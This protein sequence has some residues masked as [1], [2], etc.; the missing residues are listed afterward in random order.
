MRTKKYI[1]VLAL[2]M[3]MAA[4]VTG[5]GGG[6]AT[7]TADVVK[8]G[9]VLSQSGFLG[10][11]G[12]KMQKAV[13]MAVADINAAGG[14]NGKQVK[15]YTEDDAT[16]AAQC[17]NAVKKLVEVNGVQLMI[18][19]MTSGAANTI[20]PYL[21][22]REVL[23]LSPSA[24]AAT[25]TGQPWRDFF[26]RTTPTDAYQ[27]KVMAKLAL[28]RGLKRLVV[29]TMDNP[30]GVGLGQ[31]AEA[32]L[33]AGGAEVVGFIKYDPAKMDFLAELTQ[34]RGLNP[35]GVLH[36][37]YNDD[38]VVVYRQAND[39]GLDTA[40]WIGCD[41][42]YGTGLFRHESSAK[43][44]AKAMIGTRPAALEG[45]AKHDAFLAAYKDFTGSDAEVFCDTVYDAVM[46]IAAAA[47][48]AGSTDPIAVR[49][50]LRVIGQNYEGVSGTVTFDEG[51]DRLG[52]LYEIWGVEEADGKFEFVRLDMVDG[53]TL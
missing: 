30:Y 49:D 27:G 48:Q 4:I 31:V 39:L 21:A 42:V 7:P 20:G 43:F 10:P 51:G 18:A 13:E 36:V 25:L 41:G 1:A 53:T 8:L 17:L 33:I 15:L 34:I 28:D 3:F 23:A 22:E 9:S 6:T 19:G 45:V 11:M 2:V 12:E 37:G 46:L 24:T 14:I 32:A 5:C 40:Q 44:L 29:F 38:G 50:A 52:G 16:D 26:F 35:D 47:N